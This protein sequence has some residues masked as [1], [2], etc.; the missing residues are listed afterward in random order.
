LLKF[1]ELEEAGLLS[2]PLELANDPVTVAAKIVDTL[3]FKTPLKQRIL[4]H[5]PQV[6]KL[7]EK[8]FL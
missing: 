4:Q 7:S 3:R 2:T 8:N 5:L 6:L 1:F